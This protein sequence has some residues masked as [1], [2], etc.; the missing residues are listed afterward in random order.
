M[1]TKKNENL[2]V[3]KLCRIK[4][5]KLY[6][7][8]VES[9]KEIVLGKW[10]KASCGPLADATHVKASGCGGKLSLRPGWHTT[11]VP[12]TDWIGARQ[13]DGSLARRPDSVWCECE[14]RGDELTVTERNGLR[15]IPKGYYRF[16]TNSKQRDPW[17]RV[18]F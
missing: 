8:Y 9:D 7:L 12:W 13:P 2:L 4:S 17:L 10:L 1:S 3:Y 5:D 15:T 6:P 11:N 16:K 14:I 18:E